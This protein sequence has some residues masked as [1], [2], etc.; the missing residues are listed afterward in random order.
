MADLT[1][2]TLKQLKEL[3]EALGMSKYPQ[4]KEPLAQAIEKAYATHPLVVKTLQEYETSVK[5]SKKAPAKKTPKKTQSAVKGL[6]SAIEMGG[7]RNIELR[8]GQMEKQIAFLME[9]VAAIESHMGSSPTPQAAS[10]IE[11]SRLQKM[12]MKAVGT[13]S[14]IT[15]DDLLG[16][17]MLHGVSEADISRAVVD[18]I[19]QGVF[20]VSDANSRR[21]INGNIGLLIPR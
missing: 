5:G 10:Q 8:L 1:D 2:L 15:V 16:D 17:P 7:I 9:K 3:A 12:I 6:D 19:D 4:K 14:S 21:K 20:D 11:S 13:R 18:L